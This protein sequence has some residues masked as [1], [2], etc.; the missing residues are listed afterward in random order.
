M[1]DNSST[2]RSDSKQQSLNRNFNIGHL[3]NQEHMQYYATMNMPQNASNMASPN[4]TNSNQMLN[5]QMMGHGPS[6]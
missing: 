2:Q 3:N 6:N 4:L 1:Y 5:P